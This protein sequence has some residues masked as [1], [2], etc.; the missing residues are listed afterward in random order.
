MSNL[1]MLNMPHFLTLT[2]REHMRQC[3]FEAKGLMILKNECHSKNMYNNH[4]E[5]ITQIINPRIDKQD[6]SVPIHGFHVC[7]YYTCKTFFRE[8]Q[9]NAGVINLYCLFAVLLY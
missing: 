3:Q 6:I 1:P 9:K 2:C 4:I 8:C 5:Q 7:E